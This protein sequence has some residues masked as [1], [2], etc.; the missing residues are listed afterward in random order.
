MSL[1]SHGAGMKSGYVYIMTN[2]PS[3]TLDIGV[4]SNISAR[5]NQHRQ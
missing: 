3:G 4:T 5:A 1:V 2:A